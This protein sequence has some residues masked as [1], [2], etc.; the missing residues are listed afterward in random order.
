LHFQNHTQKKAKALAH[1]NQCYP[2]RKLKKPKLSKSKNHL[3]KIAPKKKQ[4]HQNH[5]P[6]DS[7][8]IYSNNK[9]TR[10]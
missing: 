2:H 10:E 8:N 7:L 4:H 5:P 1:Q 9:K 6:Q 3:D